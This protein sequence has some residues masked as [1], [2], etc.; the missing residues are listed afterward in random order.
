MAPPFALIVTQLLQKPG[1]ARPVNVVPTTL[2]LGFQD[3]VLGFCFIRGYSDGV[4]AGGGGVEWVDG[5]ERGTDAV[6][7]GR[8]GSGG[9]EEAG[10]VR[11]RG[12]GE[13]LLDLFGA[14]KVGEDRRAFDRCGA[15]EVEARAPGGGGRVLGWGIAGSEVEE[16]DFVGGL[17]G[18]GR[19]VEEGAVRRRRDGG[20][21]E[22]IGEGE[23]EGLDVVVGLKSGGEVE[24]VED[25]GVGGLDYEEDA[26]GEGRRGFGGAVGTVRGAEAAGEGVNAGVLG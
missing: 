22:D 16:S 2:A 3:V 9:G 23:A 8:G 11:G 4:L 7:G 13:F 17:W 18:I 10:E 12:G 20:V 1:D 19:C 21:V 25:V 26:E 14:G 24:L 15:L 6:D 5:R